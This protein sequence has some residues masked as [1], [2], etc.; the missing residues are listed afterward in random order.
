MTENKRFVL[1][2]ETNILRN[3]GENWAYWNVEQN[4]IIEKLN[5]LNDENEILSEQNERL[6]T[7]LERER[8]SHQ[9]QHEKWENEILT[10]NKQL[11]AQIEEY[12][13]ILQKK[14]E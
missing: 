5:Q 4:K 8:C 10:E 7:K 3:N 6:R 1:D 9:K 2:K 12:K 11:K 14:E 13:A